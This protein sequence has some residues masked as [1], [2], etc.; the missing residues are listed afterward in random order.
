MQQQTRRLVLM[1]HGQAEQDGQTDFERVLTE[2]GRTDTASTGAWLARQGVT[3]DHALVSAATRA[4]QT[5]DSVASGGGWVLEPELDR[6]LYAAGPETALDILHTAPAEAT[7]LVVVGHNPT[8]ATVA[9]MLDDG[10]GDV[11]A[12]TQMAMRGYPAGAATIFSYDG[13][14]A[15]LAEGTC[16]VVAFHA[17]D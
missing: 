3:P 1:R 10:D 17:P 13:T 12:S 8:I 7:T 16:S 15:E 14:W 9:Q 5:W 11:E 6:G 2:R 4:H